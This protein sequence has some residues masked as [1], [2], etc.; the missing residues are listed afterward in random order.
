MDRQPGR[1]SPP[2]ILAFLAIQFSKSTS[3]RPP[4]AAQKI[5]G[6][7]PFAGQAPD[8]RGSQASGVQRPAP[9]PGDS[10]ALTAHS[11]CAGPRS[12]T[13]GL[14]PVNPVPACFLPVLRCGHCRNPRCDAT[15]GLVG[16]SCFLQLPPKGTRRVYTVRAASTGFLK[17]SF[18]RPRQ[19]LSPL[20][21]PA[22][23][24]LPRP[25]RSSP[26]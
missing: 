23:L 18:P 13:R 8:A 21:A 7:D 15:S 3:F 26:G 11:C 22:F 17:K 10:V 4:L 14:L 5:T 12:V 1:S 2:H 20:N 19:R 16:T 9:V 6:A 24:D 25:V